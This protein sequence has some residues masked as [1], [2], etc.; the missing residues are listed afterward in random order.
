MS[1]GST[2]FPNPAGGPTAPKHSNAWALSRPLN[3]KLHAV[4]ERRRPQYHCLGG[5]WTSSRSSS[6]RPYCSIWCT[7]RA[8]PG[9]ISS[10]RDANCMWR[11]QGRKSRPHA[12]HPKTK[13]R[14]TCVAGRVSGCS[15]PFVAHCSGYACIH[16]ASVPFAVGLAHSRDT[17]SIYI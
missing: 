2:S 16:H 1:D 6:V 11:R 4:Q 9:L 13:S 3:E 17:R 5:K 15:I 7:C 8:T 12:V 10:G 14:F